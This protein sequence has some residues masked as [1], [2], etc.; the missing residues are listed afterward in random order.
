MPSSVHVVASICK[1]IGCV[2]PEVADSSDED[3]IDAIDPTFILGRDR[4]VLSRKVNGPISA[5]K[6]VVLFIFNAE[7]L[8]SRS[9]AA[10]FAIPYQRTLEV[11]LK[12]PI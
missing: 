6:W 10:S 4:V 3:I 8:L 7:L 2:P 1:R 5:F 9:F 12:V 11:G